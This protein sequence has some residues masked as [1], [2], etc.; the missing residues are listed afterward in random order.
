[1]S[2]GHFA[3]LFNKFGFLKESIV[4]EGVVCVQN[5]INHIARPK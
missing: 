2:W 4:V 1:M 5:I 3:K